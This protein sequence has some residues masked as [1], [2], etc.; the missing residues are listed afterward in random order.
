MPDA[1]GW[2]CGTSGDAEKLAGSVIGFVRLLRDFGVSVSPA[3]SADLLAALTLVDITN[4]ADVYS[5]C[6]CLLVKRHEDL[7]IFDLAFGAYWRAPSSESP[8]A[9]RSDTDGRPGSGSN[10]PAEPTPGEVGS[11]LERAGDLGAEDG[12]DQTGASSTPD[13]D[14]AE[15]T[16]ISHLADDSAAEAEDEVFTYSPAEALWDKSLS[17]LTT[18]ELAE[19][20]R[21]LAQAEWGLPKRRTR[22]TLRST[23]GPVLDQRRMAREGIR[24][25][26]EVVHLRWRQR[27]EVTRPLVFIADASGSMEPYTKVLLRFAHVLRQRYS[28]AEAFVFSTR[29]TRI[30]RDVDTVGPD[31]ALRRVSEHVGDLAGGTRIGDALHTFNRVWSR[32]ILGHGSIVVIVSDGWDRGDLELLA[33]EIA[34]LQRSCYRLVWLNPLLGRAGYVPRAAGMTTAL[35]YIDDFMPAHNLASLRALVKHLASLDSARP[36]RAQSARLRVT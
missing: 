4:R 7:A 6:R 34:H 31:T 12:D 15:L 1:S 9:P 35:P 21:L 2:V 36:V 26:G 30:T 3:Q 24:L 19:A 13:A 20:E 10:P 28:R 25:G 5:A 14:A 29:L 17:A 16:G 11:G 32:R 23:R 8:S 22:R 18:T 33:H 27:C